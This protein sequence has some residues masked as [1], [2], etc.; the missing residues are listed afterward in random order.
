MA[1]D[2]LV[3]PVV[4]GPS[5][6]HPQRVAVWLGEVFADPPAYGEALDGYRVF[7][8]SRRSGVSS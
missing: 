6:G 7:E 3:A 8:R 4:A 5:P 2:P 1:D